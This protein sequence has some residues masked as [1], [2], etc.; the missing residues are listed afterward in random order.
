[1]DERRSRIRFNPRDEEVPVPVSRVKINRSSAQESR[2]RINIGP[3]PETEHTTPER[4]SRLTGSMARFALKESAPLPKEVAI[5][6][7]S[8][9]ESTETF[10]QEGDT[11]RRIRPAEAGGDIIFRVRGIKA[12][13]AGETRISL[14]DDS[15]RRTN[16]GLADLTNE[17]VDGKTWRLET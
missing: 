5:E 10:P 8:G 12:N 7:V 6:K 16:I 17:P 3:T 15:G 13:P 2:V 14:E 9:I 11:I 4:V 1:M